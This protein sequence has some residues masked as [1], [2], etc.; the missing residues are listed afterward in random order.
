MISRV[1]VRGLL[2]YVDQELH[3]ALDNLGP[4]SAESFTA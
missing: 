4:R 1:A 3:A 2:V